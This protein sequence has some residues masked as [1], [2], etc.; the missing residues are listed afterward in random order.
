MP[1]A[2]HFDT[3][4]LGGA[5]P[6]AAEQALREASAL[7]AEP[8]LEG[9]ALMRALDPQDHVGAALIE[10]VRLRALAGIDEEADTKGAEDRHALHTGALAW[11][12]LAP[13]PAAAVCGS[14]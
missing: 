2:A 4:V 12:C 6:A 11:A 13:A 9:A 3:A 5:L 1:T 8:A 14:A 7:R 10:A